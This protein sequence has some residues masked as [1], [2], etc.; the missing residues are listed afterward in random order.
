MRP[1]GSED[2]TDLE[3]RRSGREIRHYHERDLEDADPRFVI[4]KV[5]SRREEFRTEKRWQR[6]K[7]RQSGRAVIQQQLDEMEPA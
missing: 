1:Y 2:D 4:Q 7:A 6:K 5:L 3:L